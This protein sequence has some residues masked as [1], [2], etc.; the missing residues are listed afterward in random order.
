MGA[1]GSGRRPDKRSVSECRVLSIGEL[2]ARSRRQRKPTGEI[3]WVAQRSRAT[4]ARL[5]YTITVEHWPPGPDLSV[6]ALRY[7]PTLSAAESRERIILAAQKPDLAYCPN[8]DEPLRKLYAPPGAAHFLCRSCHDLVYRRQP[9]PDRL[10]EL[11]AAMGPLLQ[12]LSAD[13]ALIADPRTPAQRRKAAAELLQTLDGE[14]PLAAEE[15]RVWCLRLGKMGLS[16]RKIARL[17]GT[18]QS[19]VQRYLAAG[20]TAIDRATLTRERLERYHDSQMAAFGGLSLRSQVRF[21]DRRA[22]QQGLHRY[23]TEPEEKV[24]L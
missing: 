14:R 13:H 6:L 23:A 24:F 9:G 5:T 1:P 4:Q 20:T 3:A 11:Q 15:L 21:L 18:S 16:C 8:C 12:G 7:W 19:S 2:A 10:A 17:A 22:K